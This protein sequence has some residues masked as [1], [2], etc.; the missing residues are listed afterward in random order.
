MAKYTEFKI[1]RLM[2]AMAA[3]EGWALPEPATGYP[4]SASFRRNNPGNLRASPLLHTTDNN[5]AVFIDEF[6]GW[7]AFKYD[8]TQKAKGNTVTGLTGESTLRDLIFKWAPPSDNNDSEKY[9]QR[10]LQYSGM[11]EGTKLKELLD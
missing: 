5:F 4:G 7:A 11:S 6:T 2:Y 1:W 8:L 3:V 10:V 9:L